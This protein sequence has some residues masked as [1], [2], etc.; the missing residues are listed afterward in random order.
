M[1]ALIFPEKQYGSRK[2]FIAQHCLLVIIENWWKCFNMD[3]LNNEL[4][5]EVTKGFDCLLHD[6]FKVKLG[7]NVFDDKPLYL[8]D[9]KLIFQ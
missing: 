8:F 1:N 4:L 3:G 9:T 6:L 2:G 5:T 7:P